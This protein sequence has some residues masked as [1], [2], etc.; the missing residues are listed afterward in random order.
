MLGSPGSYHE[1]Q[2]A[3][4]SGFPA[5]D[6][7]WEIAEK[8][9]FGIDVTAL[10]KRLNISANK[11]ITRTNNMF[12]NEQFP[13]ILGATPPRI[14]GAK[15]KV[16]G[17]D[18]QIKWQDQLGADFRYF[19]N[20]SVF[21][22]KSRIVELPDSRVIGLGVN[23]FVEG[24]IYK[25]VYGFKYDGIIQNEEEL[26]AYN[27]A[28]EGSITPYLRVG[29]ARF[30]DMDGDGVLEPF[31]YK[32]EN[33]EPTADSGDLVRIGDTMPHYMYNINFGFSWKGLDFSMLLDGIGKLYVWDGVTGEYDAPWRQP[34][35]HYYGKTWTE[36][37]P[38]AFYPKLHIRGGSVT[39]GQINGHNFRWSDASY[40]RLSNAFLAIKNV[41]VGYQLPTSW[42]NKIKTERLYVYASGTDLGFLINNMPSKSFYPYSGFNTNVMP[43]PS[44]VAFGLDINF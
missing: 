27:D 13:E 3:S 26:A 2:K 37:K 33:G 17:W 5:L 43:V 12:Y 32:T 39:G 7:S 4:S 23:D 24:E 29:D 8:T 21:D 40:K 15:M 16:N 42:A 34:L 35:D 38:Y 11:F 36:D 1:P 44:I 28:L 19:I 14:N 31:A 10:N 6:L 18:F 30:K 9:N 20:A 22:S 41:K 25:S